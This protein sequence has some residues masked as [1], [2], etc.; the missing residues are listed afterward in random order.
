MQQNQQQG[1]G[2]PLVD[3]K[4]P[5]LEDTLN[6]DLQIGDPLLVL[7]TNLDMPS[8]VEAGVT[9]TLRIVW[10][11]GR[12]NP[13]MAEANTMLLETVKTWYHAAMLI[14]LGRQSVEEVPNVFGG[15]LA[16]DFS[17]RTVDPY[18]AYLARPNTSSQHPDHSKSGIT[19]FGDVRTPAG[20]KA[21]K[22]VP[23]VCK[24]G[25]P[26]PS[27]S[28][29]LTVTEFTSTAEA[30]MWA[31]A[32]INTLD[33]IRLPMKAAADAIAKMQSQRSQGQRRQQAPQGQQSPR[34]A[35][36]AVP[37]PPSVAPHGGQ[38][39]G[40]PPVT[41]PNAPPAHVGAGTASPSTGIMLMYYDSLKKAGFEIPAG[42]RVGVRISKLKFAPTQQVTDQGQVVPAWE[43]YGFMRSGTGT[44]LP[45][46]KIWTDNPR[47]AP[48]QNQLPQV[49][50][51]TEVPFNGILWA[52]IDYDAQGREVY[53]PQM[54]ETFSP[55]KL[56]GMQTI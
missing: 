49:N 15:V 14:S 44:R 54:L 1:G 27:P 45:M 33:T 47:L 18:E 31:W 43:F 3:L 23:G 8:Y 29:T 34:N 24:P 25:D 19:I 13:A 55:E 38:Q 9:Y 20:R 37:P 11:I 30:V 2:I 6:W 51:G 42:T 36:P 7:N 5:Q 10:R 39:S 48:I 12:N 26:L 32:Q 4:Y 22:E 16:A 21:T 41:T 28:L 56:E 52:T 17:D 46:F 35:P 40:P 53:N 50:M